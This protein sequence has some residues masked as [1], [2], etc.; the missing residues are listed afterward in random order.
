MRII[1]VKIEIIVSC[2]VWPLYGSERPSTLLRVYFPSKIGYRRRIQ[3]AIW[4]KWLSYSEF[5]VQIS[6]KWT[7][8]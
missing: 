6:V 2:L 1:F 3:S 5:G 4:P 8:W 7:R